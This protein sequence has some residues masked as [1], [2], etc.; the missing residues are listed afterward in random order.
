MKPLTPGILGEASHTHMME[1]CLLGG[2]GCPISETF[3][4]FVAI[5]WTSLCDAPAV[6][7]PSAERKL[8][9]RCRNPFLP[10]VEL[11]L[12]ALGPAEWIVF[13]MFPSRGLTRKL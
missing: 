7:S 11:N 3:V 13:D 4:T 6:V 12:P 5:D 9:N 2:E 1:F 8:E 10:K